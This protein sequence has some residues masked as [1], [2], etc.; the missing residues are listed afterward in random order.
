MNQVM[1]ASGLVVVVILWGMCGCDLP[2]R[3]DIALLRRPAVWEV[4]VSAPVIRD[5]DAGFA[6][7]QTPEPRSDVSSQNW[8]DWY[9][10]CLESDESDSESL[11]SQRKFVLGGVHMRA[12]GKQVQ[13]SERVLVRSSDIRTPGG[14]VRN[15]DAQADLLLPNHTLCLNAN[16]Q[17]F[18]HDDEGHLERVECKVRQGPVESSKTI[19]ISED[20]VRIEPT[21][22]NGAKVKVLKKSG[23]LGGPLMVYR[24]L[25]ANPLLAG[26]VR[27]S[28]VFLPINES[29]AK[30]RLV[31]NPRAL[32][33]RLGA[34][35]VVVD[36]LNEALG[37]VSIEGSPPR[38]RFYW[39][40][41][42]GVVQ[43]TQISDEGGFTYRC[44]EDQ[45]QSLGQDF[46]THRY[47]ITVEIPGKP[48]AIS[49]EGMFVKQLAV[50][51]QLL[52]Q[53]SESTVVVDR[54][55]LSA[56]PRQYV[57]VLD[58]QNQRVITAFRPVPAKR[59][60]G[61]FET[62][63]PESSQADLAATKILDFRSAAMR[64]V[65]GTTSSLR[66]LDQRDQ[67]EQI[68]RTIH[69]L[70]SFQN[71]STGIRPASQIVQST[72]ADS[73]EHA[74]VLI[75]M[76]RANR[77]PARMA[78]GLRY[79]ESGESSQSGASQEAVNRFGYHAWV[80]AEVDQEWLALDPTIGEPVG[81][82]CIALEINDLSKLNA[83]QFTDR[84]LGILRS[85]RLT[86]HAAVIGKR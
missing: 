68:N 10:H 30:L 54:P 59:L 33:K 39:Y 83:G 16:K 32:A 66:G 76:L 72:A 53:A 11:A 75:A 48:I 20:S 18:W 22:G 44:D 61:R 15:A 60:A 81:A 51:V 50:N 46:L 71:L 38:Y 25:R 42:D 58:E 57:Q 40:D 31:G 43:A 73:T 77:I 1:R 36:S 79:L 63:E 2:D 9:L 86:V 19:L 29:L 5:G 26:Q 80:V 67:A 84:F 37:A 7:T 3:H 41:D 65:L 74:I 27:E 14:L 62:F 6:R 49:E 21:S 45:Y 55:R 34:D 13:L 70:L 64:K 12:D 78:V 52:P 69:S 8:Q 85:V 47:P 56:A 82:E 35:G 23:P 24:S 4:E 17:T 28:A